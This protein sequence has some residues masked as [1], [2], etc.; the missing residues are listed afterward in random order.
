MIEEEEKGTEGAGDN[1]HLFE[2]LI[3]TIWTTGVI[4]RQMY[5]VIIVLIPK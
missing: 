5:W 1:W 2:S 3:Q 4:P